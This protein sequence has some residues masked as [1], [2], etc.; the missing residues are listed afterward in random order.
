MK[1]DGE[2]TE[3]RMIL[4]GGRKEG[5]NGGWEGGYQQSANKGRIGLETD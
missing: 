3:E 2:T 5:R 1:G 4:Q